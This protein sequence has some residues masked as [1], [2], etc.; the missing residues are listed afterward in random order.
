MSATTSGHK[1]SK[2]PITITK[3]V[4]VVSSPVPVFPAKRL[5]SVP[6]GMPTA[7][8][9]EDTDMGQVLI[10]SNIGGQACSIDPAG[11]SVTPHFPAERYI[12]L[13]PDSTGYALPGNVEAYKNGISVEDIPDLRIFSAPSAQKSSYEGL[14]FKHYGK[15]YTMPRLGSSYPKLEDRM[16]I[17]GWEPAIGSVGKVYT[18]LPFEA[19][20]D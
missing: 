5:S 3:S 4:K 13:N 6:K 14:W 1:D 9:H 20:I 17:D 12:V 2:M 16:G 7:V 11:W 18:V 19:K 15:L 10:R 8:T